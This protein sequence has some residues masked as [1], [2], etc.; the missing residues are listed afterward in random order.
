M[1]E[2]NW[3]E[4]AEKIAQDKYEIGQDKDNIYRVNWR[5]RNWSLE[6]YEFEAVVEAGSNGLNLFLSS[7]VRLFLGDGLYS[8]T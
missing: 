2:L 8:C 5:L 3:G 7:K 4:M 6:L 1:S